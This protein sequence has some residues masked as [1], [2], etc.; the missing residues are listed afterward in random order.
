MNVR[1]KQ[2]KPNHRQFIVIGLVVLGAIYHFSRP[3]LEKWF[4]TSLPSIMQGDHQHANNSQNNGGN[5]Y[6]AKLPDSK[7]GNGSSHDSGNAGQEARNWLTEIG[8]GEYKSP[9]GLIYGRGKE[10]RIDHVLLHCKDDPSKPTH[11]VFV[12]ST[13]EVMEMIDEA[14]ELAK[15]GSSK[16]DSKK[17]G[18]KMTHTVSMGR[19]VGHTG[20]KKAQRSGRKELK[21]IKLVLAKNRV[22]TAFPK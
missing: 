20:G 13:V 17:S 21:S 19:V 5:D 1:A 3:T 9:A 14:Y 18:D 15:S 2:R 12:G 6:N 8:R 16:S 11:G 10:H 4:N 7:S 22:I